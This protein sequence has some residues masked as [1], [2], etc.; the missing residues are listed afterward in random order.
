MAMDL[1]GFDIDSWL[2]PQ[3]IAY[4]VGGVGIVIEWR[5]YWLP[6]AK[7][8]RSWSA[9]GAL[10]WAIQYCVLNAWTAGLTMA[11]TSLRTFLSDSLTIGV[12]K[13]AAA[14][15]FSL[16]FSLLTFFSWQGLISLLPAFAVLNTTW[17][18]FYLD[19]RWMRLA[20]V[21]SSGAWMLNDIL[22]QAWPALL[23][24]S[25]AVVI[26]LRT[27]YRLFFTADAL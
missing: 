12:A 19:N 2:N 13:H 15:T 1:I 26:N 24:E 6:G 22:W 8:F 4:A 5:A 10:L 3:M 23:A 25:V 20:L 16:L 18:L 14:L 7:E 27:L 21:A 9:A 17:A 11:C